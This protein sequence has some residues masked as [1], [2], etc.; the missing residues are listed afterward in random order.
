MLVFGI[1]LFALGIM[2]SI[3]L[4]EY[5]H[6]RVALWSGMRV[7]RFFVGFGPTLW[8]VR[9][10]GIEYGLK[11]I[12]LG[13]LPFTLG[14]R[15]CLPVDKPLA[16][17]R[18]KLRRIKP[19]EFGGNGIRISGFRARYHATQANGDDQRTQCKAL[20]HHRLKHE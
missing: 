19:D 1:V 4:H 20:G 3:V 10:G 9:R 18:A 17:T 5:G 14:F 6:M 12:P 13:G 11:A 8:S 7:R 15:K 16:G 2:V